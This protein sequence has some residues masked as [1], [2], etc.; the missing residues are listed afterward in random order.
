MFT[1]PLPHEQLPA[2]LEACTAAPLLRA[3]C[4]PTSPRSLGFPARTHD[5]TEPARRIG[6]QQFRL[7]PHQSEAEGR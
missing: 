4:G 7:T 2:G 6:I 5:L 3:T 1:Q